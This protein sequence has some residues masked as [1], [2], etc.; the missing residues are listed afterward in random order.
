M[1]SQLEFS[2]AR[3]IRVI[4]HLTMKISPSGIPVYRVVIE[5]WTH[6]YRIE[7]I[8]ARDEKPFAYKWVM[9]DLNNEE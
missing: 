9:E 1:G 8:L 2:A 6:G 4:S 7:G 5:T 3:S